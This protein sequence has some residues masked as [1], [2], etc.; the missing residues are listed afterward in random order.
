MSEYIEEYYALVDQLAAYF[1]SNDPLYYVLRFVDGLRDD[2][3]SVVLVQHPRD[4][5]TAV[6]LASLQDEVGDFS[7]R[8]D[9]RRF[10]SVPSFKPQL[11]G[12]SS[13]A[14]SPSSSSAVSASTLG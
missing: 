7:R 5:D 4:L 11:L 8:K 9:S 3:K 6:A 13:S 1:S 2:I 10:D 14:T 12:G